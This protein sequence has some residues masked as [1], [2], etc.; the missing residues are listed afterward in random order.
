[1]KT[2]SFII[3]SLISVYAN[4][5]HIVGR[6]TNLE[7]GEPIPYANVWI[8]NK[9]L[10]T[11]SDAHGK[12]VVDVS[13]ARDTCTLGFSSLGYQKRYINLKNYRTTILNRKSVNIKLTPKSFQ[14]PE[15]VVLGQKPNIAKLNGLSKS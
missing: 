11:V 6:V 10:C 2:L 14:I 4:A 1:M 7:T 3:L 13:N 5:Q 12:F 9:N 8:Q 15:V